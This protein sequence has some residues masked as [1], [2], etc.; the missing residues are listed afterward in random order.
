VIRKCDSCSHASQEARGAALPITAAELVRVECDAEVVREADIAAAE[1][2][3]ARRPVPTLTIPTKVRD[4]VWARDC[5]RCRF[6]GCRATRNL[7][8]HHLEFQMH[9]GQHVESNLILLC[10]G[11]HKLLHDGVISITG[12]APEQ[13]VFARDGR[14][15]VDPGAP[16]E[17]RAAADLRAETPKPTSRFDEVVKLEHAKQALMQLGLKGR[18]AR[19]ALETA[20]THV[21]RDADVPALVEAVLA[22]NRDA[23][24]DDD[25]ADTPTLAKRALV[26]SGYPTVLATEAVEAAQTHVGPHAAL[27]LLIMEAFRRCAAG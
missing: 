3:G 24:I 1:A 19:R 21:G 9:G 8:F 14:R 20:L 13:L 6:P 18:D 12:R 10:D 5:G 27:E 15:L 2:R 26:Q 11:H 22:M 16:S 4:L 7:A 17:Q 25:N 23:A